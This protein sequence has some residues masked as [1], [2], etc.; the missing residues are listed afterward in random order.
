MT[1]SQKQIHTLITFYTNEVIR[2]RGK[3][4]NDVNL[5]RDKWGFKAMIEQ[6]GFDRAKEIVTYFVETNPHGK[7][8]KLM[9][10]YD[11][12]AVIMDEREQDRLLRERLREQ[13]ARRVAEWRANGNK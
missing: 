10:T 6:F 5:N 9:H 7:T 13:S 12:V 1:I 8:A 11:A 4:P 2:V 3:A